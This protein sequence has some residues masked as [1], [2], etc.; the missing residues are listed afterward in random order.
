MHNAD[1]RTA[2]PLQSD[3]PG[4]I[5]RA[6][7]TSIGGVLGKMAVE[8][9]KRQYLCSGDYGTTRPNGDRHQKSVAAEGVTSPRND[10]ALTGF[11]AAVLSSRCR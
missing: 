7:Q 3:C 6:G 2:C 5:P 9:P 11:P 1:G 8:F 10:S 4:D